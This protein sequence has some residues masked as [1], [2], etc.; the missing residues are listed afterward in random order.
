[1]IWRE[2][3][4]NSDQAAAQF[5]HN[6]DDMLDLST[7]ISPI[8]YPAATISAQ[9]WNQLPSKSQLNRCLAAARSAYDVP[10]NLAIMAGAGTQSLLQV[11]PSLGPM[12]GN[13]WI[14]EPTYN[15]HRP[16]WVSSGYDVISGNTA[17]DDA[18][19]AVFVAPNNPTG[20]IDRVGIADMTTR[21]P[22]ARPDTRP[23][24]RPNTN[25]DTGPNTDAGAGAG[26]G[27]DIDTDTG[28]LILI[29]GAFALPAAAD[30]GASDLL[31]E[32]SADPHVIHLRSFG[33]FFGMAGLRLGFAIGAPELIAKL[34]ARIGPWAV[35]SAALD[36]GT[37]ALN[38]HAWQAQ[39]GVFLE[40]Q[41]ERLKGLLAS[42]G[43]T[44]L[45]GTSLFQTVQTPDAEALHTHL[46][47]A[48]IWTR[49]FSQ[50]PDLL[51]FGVPSGE[52]DFAR[53]SKTL[54]NWQN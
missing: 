30:T 29:D 32:F 40:G 22:N 33:K 35:S 15:E 50:S 9:S 27:T 14:A 43:F 23:N 37:A 26:A 19:S 18:Q 48:A 38:D 21:R 41:A 52:T 34:Q 11:I 36:I 39:H 12:S 53:L 8:A 2:H 16:A 42:T 1:M 17:P 13:V 20:L 47:K 46:A 24:T 6:A 51:R 4:G 7:G 45:G 54:E 5:G 3:G 31:H 44:I 25:T 49:K 10:H 28:G